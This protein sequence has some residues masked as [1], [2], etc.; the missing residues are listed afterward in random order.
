M[1]CLIMLPSSDSNVRPDKILLFNQLALGLFAGSGHG[2]IE[3]PVICEFLHFRC[4][5]QVS[6]CSPSNFIFG[7][8]GEGAYSR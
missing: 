8:K 6:D 5:S 1:M 3:T 7:Q 4:T 2:S